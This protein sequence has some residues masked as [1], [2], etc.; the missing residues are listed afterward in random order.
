MRRVLVVSERVPFV[1]GPIDAIGAALT[2]ALQSPATDVEFIGL[3][4][5]EPGGA[6]LEELVARRALDV[7]NVDRL[8]ALSFPACLIPHP[9]KIVWLLDDER[10]AGH[11]HGL[12]L[13][14]KDA[15]RVYT[16]SAKARMQLWNATRHSSRVLPIPDNPSSWRRAAME[17]L[18]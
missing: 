1:E 8:I 6:S 18:K 15:K 9:Q 5:R 10:V 3:P 4:C 2:R 7:W 13:G 12:D 16:A 14:L 11:P 17:L